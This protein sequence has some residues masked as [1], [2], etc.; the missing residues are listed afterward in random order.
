MRRTGRAVVGGEV[1]DDG[2]DLAGVVVLL[3]LAVLADVEERH[4]H[5]VELLAA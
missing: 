2:G 4:F 1:R 3:D 5:H